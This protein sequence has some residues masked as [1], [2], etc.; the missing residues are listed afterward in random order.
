MSQLLHLII[1]D[2]TATTVIELVSG[3]DSL[4]HCPTTTKRYHSE[5]PGKQPKVQV[6]WNL[7]IY[8]DQSRPLDFFIACSSVSGVCGNA[9]Q[10]QY[11]AGDA[12]QDALAHHRRTQGL[13]AI[14]VNLGI[15]RDVGSLAK[16]TATGIGN[17]LSQWEQIIGI[18]ETA[19]HSLMKSLIIRQRNDDT[20][21][22]Q[23]S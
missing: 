10:A 12:Y 3:D 14:S 4:S 13:K 11:A 6:T 18:R 22:A 23:V 1:Y 20:C 5:K 2:K 17:N 19:F 16:A 8:F 9:D 21:P 7:H 15:M